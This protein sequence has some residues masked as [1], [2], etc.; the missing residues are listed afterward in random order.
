MVYG[1]SHNIEH[2]KV[3][4]HLCTMKFLTI[5]LKSNCVW[6]GI[7]QKLTE[8]FIFSNELVSHSLINLYLV[9]SKLNNS[10]SYCV[11]KP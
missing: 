6:Y 9:Q 4:R 7:T 1:N 2:Q 3:R 5:G 11:L 8:F 10:L